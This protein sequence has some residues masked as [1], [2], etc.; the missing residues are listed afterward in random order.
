[1]NSSGQSPHIFGPLPQATYEA[2]TRVALDNNS[3]PLYGHQHLQQQQQQQQQRQSYNNT[4]N[5]YGST[6]A[7]GGVAQLNQQQRHNQQ[8]QHYPQYRNSSIRWNQVIT[9]SP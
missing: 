8:Q 6:A 1:M 9:K 3:P 4:S 2:S 7:S 5:G